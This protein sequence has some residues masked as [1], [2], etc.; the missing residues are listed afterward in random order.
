[1]KTFVKLLTLIALLSLIAGCASTPA[2]APA[3]DAPAEDTSAAE[4]EEAPASGLSEAEQWAKANGFGPYQAA[5]EDWAAI[6][7]AALEEGEVV[8][9][10]NSSKGIGCF[11]LNSV[12]TPQVSK[13]TANPVPTAKVTA[14]T[15]YWNKLFRTNSKVYFVPSCISEGELISM[16]PSA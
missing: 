16:P 9:Y 10:S 15:A 8:V 5:E 7:A 4:D 13:P 1:M 3:A 11:L 14:P 12:N 2:E 6:E